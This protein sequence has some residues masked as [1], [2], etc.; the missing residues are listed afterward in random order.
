MQKPALKWMAISCPHVPLEDKDTK[1]WIL[2]RAQEIKPDL[3]VLLGDGMEGSP[4]SRHPNEDTWTGL[5]EF[6][7][8]ND[9]LKDLREAAGNQARL[10]WTLGNH[11]FN[12]LDK[13]RVDK[14]LRGF[15][16]W[17]ANPDLIPETKH[18][19]QLDYSHRQQFWYG[20]ICF[21]HGAEH[22]L[23]CDR[24]QAAIY[25]GEN[26]LVIGGHSHRGSD[27]REVMLTNTIPLRIYFANAGCGV[28]WTKLDYMNRRNYAM[29][30]HSLLTGDVAEASVRH[31][32]RHYASIQW[33]A[34]FE[35]LKRG[36]GR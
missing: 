3:F 8:F 33:T 22:G 23:N 5:Q 18:W 16:D 6:A 28:D 4:P 27:V 25:G 35:L 1:K 26:K 32:A 13:C 21:R 31:R 2:S 17:R 29:W 12:W 19:Q 36:D 34:N 24:N 20:P 7:K 14:R 15:V 11:D 10:V 30:T 9:Y